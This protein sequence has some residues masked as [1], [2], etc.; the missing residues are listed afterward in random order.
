MA[1]Y[2]IFVVSDGTGETATKMSKAALLQFKPANTTFVRHS[3]VRSVDMVREI[4]RAAEREPALVI[5]TFASRRLRQEMEQACQEFNVASLDL[6]GPLIEKLAEFIET[7]PAETPGLL[8][9][10]DDDY[11]DRIDALAFTVRH[12]DNR[13]PE[14]LH[15]A[16]IILVGVS[17]TS[18]TPLGIYL[19]QE[20]WKVANI[21]VVMG[22]EL[23]RE[24]FQV[25]QSRIVGLM[26]TPERLAEV[27]KAR[28]SRLGSL[29]STYA[30]MKRVAAELEYC[31]KIFEQN[32]D[33][34]LVDVAGKSVEET[35]AEILDRLFGKERRL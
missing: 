33:W 17:R 21:P 35:A 25:Y 3:N 5:H 16:D 32:A 30:D 12:D 15:E 7:Q 18:K 22:E 23:P 6:I 24:L 27:R 4:V 29:D 11:F 10:V 19:G 14:D 26:T 13:S 1:E 8:H 20:G 9:Q 2:H 34:L 31:R 28:L